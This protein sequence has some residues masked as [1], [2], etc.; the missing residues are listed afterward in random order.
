MSDRAQLEALR[1]D[2]ADAR[3]TVAAIG[4]RVPVLAWKVRRHCADAIEHLL[5]A[6][7]AVSSAAIELDATR[8]P[9]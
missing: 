4:D 3:A 2:L 8:P 1:R 6:E 5:H 9:R 7:N